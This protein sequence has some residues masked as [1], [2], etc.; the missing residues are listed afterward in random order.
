MQ[1]VVLR[2]LL[3]GVVSAPVEVG[4]DRPACQ[5]NELAIEIGRQEIAGI[6][7]PQTLDVAGWQVLGIRVGRGLDDPIASRWIALPALI[8]EPKAFGRC[9]Y[10]D[11]VQ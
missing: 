4:I 8:Y 5:V 9:R 10:G 6:T 2:N 11:C 1:R 3:G 7:V